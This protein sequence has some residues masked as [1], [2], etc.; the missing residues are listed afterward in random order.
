MSAE[1]SQV[2][3]IVTGKV[4]QKL[5]ETH[6][7]PKTDETSPIGMFDSGVGG[8]SVL[9]QVQKQLPKESVI[10]LGDTA[11]VPFG[12]RSQKEI[13][14]FNYQIMNYL[15]ERG[16][17][18]VIIA[19]GTSSALAYPAIKDRYKIPIVSLIVPGAR[20][21]FEAS[22]NKKIGVIAT[23]GTIGS[24]AYKKAIKDI[25]RSAEVFENPCPLFVP[26]IEGGF[27][28]TDEMA[29]VAKEY[30]APL[31][32]AGIDTLILGCTHYPHIRKT[33][34]DI[35]GDN[36]TLIDPAEETIKD[37]R[38]ILLRSHLASTGK[39]PPSYQFVVTGN[40]ESF[41]AVGSKLLGKPL[42]DVKQVS[43]K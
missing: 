43:L 39:R 41:A 42:G 17:K 13:I 35:V 7:P 37:A 32:K 14:T 3:T 21:A 38:Q 36:V 10:Y 12:G 16:V 27:A 15:V 26:L 22:K 1:I 34:K 30:L 31:T 25:N 6:E 18:M 24:H 28:E 33:I 8:L 23:V 2:R 5:H 19:C 29:R 9:K 11:R 4:V 40:P 20:A